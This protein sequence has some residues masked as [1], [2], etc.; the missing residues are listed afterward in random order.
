MPGEAVAAKPNA[1]STATPPPPRPPGARFVI[2]VPDVARIAHHRAGDDHR[3][4]DRRIARGLEKVES[5]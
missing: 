5:N 4:D 3:G 1:R 2:E